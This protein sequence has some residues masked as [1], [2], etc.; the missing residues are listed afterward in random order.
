M[1]R[2]HLILPS[3][4]LPAAT[5]SERVVLLTLQKM[6]AR[7][8]NQPDFSPSGLEAHLCQIFGVAQQQDWP[9][10]AIGAR[11][12]GLPDGVWLR[13]DPV[14]L[15]L[16]RDRLLLSEISVSAEEAQQS[17]AALNAYFLEQDLRFYAPH[18]QR[19]YVQ[20]PAVPCMDTVPLSQMLG[21]NV[22]HALPKG[23]DA[24][25]WHQVFNEIQMLLFSLPLNLAREERGQPPLNSVWFWGAGATPT[26]LSAPYTSV[27][28]DNALTAHFAAAAGVTFTPW[29]GRWNGEELLVWNAPHHAL[30]QGDFAQWQEVLQQFEQHYAQPLWQ[31]LSNGEITQLRIDILDAASP[32]RLELA[33][34]DTWAVWRRSSTL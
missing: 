17:C 10:A 7:G 32:L 5:Q 14:H 21:E 9:L 3:L 24:A 27:S 30:R 6:L 18:P 19:W 22:R 11:A 20:L 16:Q 4:F 23:E 25:H 8:R 2:V 33:R 26:E 15:Y 31:A 13:A 12:D 1:K 34:R 29:Q 28:A